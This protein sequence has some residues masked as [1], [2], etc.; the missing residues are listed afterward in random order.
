MV[1]EGDLTWGGEYAREH[2]DDVVQ[3]CT[4]ETYIILLTKV[5]PIN[6]IKIGSYKQ[7]QVCK[8]QH[9]KYSKKNSNN[10][11]WCQVGTGNIG[12]MGHAL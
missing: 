11:V 12:V 3:N 7:S 1:M 10:Y 8:V 6:S 2:T 4:P 9:R 5:N